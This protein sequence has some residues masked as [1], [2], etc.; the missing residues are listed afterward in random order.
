MKFWPNKALL[1]V[2]AASLG[3]ALPAFS[4]D[5]DAPESLLPPGF[6]DPQALPPPEEKAPPAPTVQPDRPATTALPATQERPGDDEE[7]LENLDPLERPRPLNYFTI[8]EGAARPVDM[9]GPLEPANFGLGAA[10]FGRANGVLLTTLMQR[11]DAPVPSRWTS[12]LLRRALLSRVAAPR[13]VHPV[14]WVAARA[15]LLLRMG[16]ADAARL[17]VQSVDQENYTPRMIEVAARTALATSDPAGLCPLVGPADSSQTVWRLADAICAALEGEPARASTLVDEARRRGDIGGIDIAL[18]EKVIGAGVEARRAASLLWDPVAELT[19]WR[20]GLAGAT[21]AEIPDRLTDGAAPAMLAWYARAPMVPLERRLGAAEIAASLGVFSSGSLVEIH[22]LMLDQT[23]PAEQAGTVGARLRT[24]WADRDQ[25]ER[26]EAMRSLWRDEPDGPRHH[27]RLILTAGAASHIAPSAD[28]SGDAAELIASMLTAGLD[29]A[30]A[31][32]SAV[33][34]ESGDDRAWAL[35]AV[36]A[37]QPAVDLG[38]GRIDSFVDND[39]SS[40]RRRAQFLVAALAGLGRIDAA[41][42]SRLAARLG[43]DLGRTDRWSAA[44][45]RAARNRE[46]GTVALLAAV[47]MQTGDWYGVPPEYL[48]RIIRALRAVGHEYEARMIAAEAITRL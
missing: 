24:A 21:G 30:A 16:E 47:G 45:D 33:V 6:G 43:A 15:E 14:D 23:D 32:W 3:V 4:Q 5:R 36:G 1:L 26:L 18:T 25:G 12:M 37:P 17:L 27:A 10:A 7:E 2:G 13:L 40:G 38:S 39:D 46:A 19:A 34:Q 31:R 41:E 29:R 20:L 35:L 42:A 22:S 8:P 9:V 28:R 48:F 44:I 11:L